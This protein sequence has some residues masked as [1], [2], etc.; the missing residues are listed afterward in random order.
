MPC[1]QDVYYKTDTHWNSLGAYYGYV[2]IMNVLARKYPELGPH[3]LSDFEYENTGYDVKDI[4]KMM[5][6]SNYKE[7][8]RALIPKFKIDLNQTST[9]LH[10][11]ADAARIVTNK[12]NASS[13]K[14]LVFHDSFYNALSA[15]IEP[16]FDKV[17]TVPFTD[18]KE[19][20]SLDWIQREEPNI[21]I[22]E[23]VE[24]Y[25]DASLP[26]LLNN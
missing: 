11:G 23:V 8:N 5:G 6:L 4:P 18:K 21:V 14:L 12:N 13:L 24:R 25:L 7:E 20:W 22:I 15:F 1:S 10:F 26:K 17:V 9:I 2:E 19:I 16:H 3:P